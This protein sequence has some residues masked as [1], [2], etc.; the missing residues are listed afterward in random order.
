[1]ATDKLPMLQEGY[2]KLFS[3]LKALREERPKVVDAIF[4][5]M[6]NTM[7]QKSVRVRSKRRLPILKT[8]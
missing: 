4:P 1:M 8:N 5:K 2:D 6:P 7:P 3:E